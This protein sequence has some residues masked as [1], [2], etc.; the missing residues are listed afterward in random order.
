MQYEE[1]I[2]YLQ[3][4]IKNKVT[5]KD[6]GEALNITKQAVGNKKVAGYIF[7][8]FEI[9]KVKNY[10]L[11]KY[12]QDNLSNIDNSLITSDRIEIQYWPELPD[13]FK[14]PKIRSVWFD[15]E[16]IEN[17]WFVNPE[18]LFIIPMLGDALSTFWYRINDGDLLIID[19]E[20]N[21]VIE[22]AIYFA[23]SRNSS[24]FWIREIDILANDIIEFHR[25]TQG[26]KIVKTYNREELK[27]LDFQII[28]Q[29]IKN[30]SFRI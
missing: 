25:Y 3:N 16:V 24:M 14:N 29:V 23:T 21:E 9:E 18:K 30:I 4:L 8:D 19:T 26:G 10:I 13:K 28:G 15:R 22:P 6:V 7:K 17:K 5:Q 11:N 20:H 27:N 12:S 1:L 2:D